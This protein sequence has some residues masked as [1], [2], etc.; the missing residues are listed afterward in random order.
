MKNFIQNFI[1]NFI[2]KV[3]PVF[4]PLKRHPLIT[5]GLFIL[6]LI[7]C[8]ISAQFFLKRAKDKQGDGNLI[9]GICLY[10]LVA[11]L[12]YK[13]LGFHKFGILNIIWHISMFLVTLGVG[14]FIF[15]ERYNFKE[16]LG[17]I[18]G[19]IALVLLSSQHKH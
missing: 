2:H 8:E 18:F 10:A 14:Y 5:S 13:S 4:Q 6:A 7:I 12:F 15:E 17:I 16:Q 11:F 19:I 9:I 1:Q 3:V